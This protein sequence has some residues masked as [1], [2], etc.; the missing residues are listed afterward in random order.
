[1]TEET[2]DN[3]DA[4]EPEEDFAAMLEA[5]LGGK[6]APRLEP[7]QKIR[8]KVLAFSGDWA[9]LDVG[10][11]GEGVL[12]RRELLDDEGQLTVAL[13]DM[14][15][16]YFL[17][18]SGGE[19]RFA[20]RIGGAA[21]RSDL[22]EAWKSGIPV[23]GQV[24]KEIK[25][26][27][28]IRLA[29]QTRAF[30]PFSQMG[31][32][33]SESSAEWIGRTLPFRISQYGEQ[34]RN[35]VVSHRAVLEEER[36]QQRAKLRETLR[37]GQTVRGTVTSLRDFGAFIDIGGVEGLLP[38]SELAWGRVADIRDVL[39]EG[40]EIA[41]C[42]KSID[43][44]ENRFSFSRKD[45]LDDP[46]ALVARD[47]PE[48]SLHTGKVSR[49]APFGAFVTLGEGID[50]LVHI[51]KIGGGK[52]INHPREV[53]KEGQDLAVRVEKIDSAER[54]ISLV[55]AAQESAEAGEAD[56]RSYLQEERGAGLGTLGDLLKKPQE[57]KQKGKKK[58]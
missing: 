32:R 27:F 53:L 45:T 52:R 35:I 49:L 37:E 16:V 41:V 29:A 5:S 38:I 17:S 36:E 4:E 44:A 13:G 19:L 1:M 50:G 14:L 33:R 46:W 10:Q 2:K 43:W 26:G 28:E 58:K 11:K 48:G 30:C 12:D 47:F 39:H 55:P 42:I 6:A 15:D 56:V 3:H 8:A 25:G 51:S 7:G 20:L 23:D 57:K 18:R 54:R 31:L 24:E 9:F 34:G 21:G 22:E 40:Q